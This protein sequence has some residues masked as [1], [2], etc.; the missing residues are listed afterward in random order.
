MGNLKEKLIQRKM[1]KSGHF[2]DYCI[3]CKEKTLDVNPHL[4]TTA[5]G[6]LA[7]ASTCNVCGTRKFCFVSQKGGS[8]A[9]VGAIASAVP[10]AIGKI[11]EASNRGRELDHEFN[12][13]NGNL[14]YQKNNRFLEYYRNLLHNR[15]WN[16]EM[17]P[18][19]L[20]LPRFETNN[21]KF[22]AKQEEKDNAMWNYAIETW[23]GH[24]TKI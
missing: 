11:G 10:E 23:D 12:R 8:A 20:R 1:A 9:I 15:F 2:Y 13:E 7:R 4:V 24:Q 17:F 21:P 19:Y 16:Q 18:P 6:R 3:K 5:T 14:Q 22:A